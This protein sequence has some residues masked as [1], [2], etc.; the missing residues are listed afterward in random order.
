MLMAPP[1]TERMITYK[2]ITRPPC[3]ATTGAFWP[4]VV[5]GTMVVGPGGSPGTLALPG[6]VAAAGVVAEVVFTAAAVESFD[7][8]GMAGAV[9]EVAGV[10]PPVVG[11]G[12]GVA[13]A[14]NEYPPIFSAHCVSPLS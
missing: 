1:I 3:T 13:G 8:A 12:V 6:E 11:A 2:G 5:V 4:P 14:S 9:P 10:A 7:A